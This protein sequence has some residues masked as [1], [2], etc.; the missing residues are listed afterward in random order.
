MGEMY[1]WLHEF[2][3]WALGVGEFHVP[4]ALSTDNYTLYLLDRKVGSSPE[5]V[6]TLKNAPAGNQSTIRRFSNP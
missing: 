1:V 3:T 2:V 5:Q 6:W 4:A